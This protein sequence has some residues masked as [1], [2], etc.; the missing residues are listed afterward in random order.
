M[1]MVFDYLRRAV[2]WS[3]EGGPSTWFFRKLEPLVPLHVTISG[4]LRFQNFKEQ[5]FSTG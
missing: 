5:S 2:I 3:W 4:S 1:Q